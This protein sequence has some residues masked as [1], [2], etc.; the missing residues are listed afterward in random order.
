M[1]TFTVIECLA[2]GGAVRFGQAERRTGEKKFDS[3][4]LRAGRADAQAPLSKHRPDKARNAKA[5]LGGLDPH[6]TSSL[7]VDGNGHVGHK[8]K[9][10][11]FANLSTSEFVS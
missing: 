8:P 10:Q 9:I 6:P 5:G 2:G 11:K 1:K 4:S 3:C 7:V